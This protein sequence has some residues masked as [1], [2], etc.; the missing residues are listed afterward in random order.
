[1]RP[2]NVDLPLPDGPTMASRWPA[3]T[4]RSSGCRMVSGWP[5]LETV[6]ETPR[7]L[8]MNG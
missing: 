2:I 8:I 7:R 3:F 4:S 6:F 5:P 1:M